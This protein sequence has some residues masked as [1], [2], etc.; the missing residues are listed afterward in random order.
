M[1]QN[2]YVI[3]VDLGGT[4]L[5][6][7]AVSSKGEV[8]FLEKIPSRSKA[9]T[10][11]ALEMIAASI[12]KVR[13]KIMTEKKNIIGIGMGFPG[14]VDPKK[15]IVYRSPHF[16]DWKE[17]EVGSFFQKRFG[18]PVKIDNDCH[19]IARGEMWKGAAQGLKNLIFLTLGTGIGGGIVWKGDIVSG[20]SGFAGEVGHLVIEREG[21]SCACGSQGCWEMYA[22]ATGILREVE[23]EVQQDSE[24]EKMLEKAGG[25]EKITV[26]KIYES[27]R[28]GNLYAHSVFKKLGYHLAIG[29]A[30]LVNVT[31]IETIV[32]GGGVSR[33]WDFFIKPLQTELEERTYEESFKRLK[34]KRAERGDEAGLLGSAMELFENT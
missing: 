24:R 21:R 32:I 12:Q 15:G 7:G 23:D 22:S 28:D 29:I 9:K 3:A 17:V 31:G 11:E 30:S 10:S 8:E 18:L 6:V 2:E 19:M 25:I 14:I 13:D 33:A 27:A 26:A 16:P 4:H 5:R 34:L 20:D 1:S